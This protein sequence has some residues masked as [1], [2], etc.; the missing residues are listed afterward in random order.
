MFIELAPPTYNINDEYHR[1]RNNWRSYGFSRKRYN[2]CSWTLDWANTNRLVEERPMKLIH[3]TTFLILLL[4]SVCFAY[5]YGHDEGY[6]LVES[7]LKE[8]AEEVYNRCPNVTAYAIMLE[9]ENA[10]LNNCLLYTSPSPRD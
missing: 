6:L 4:I 1:A 9:N 2:D 8:C 5:Q 3:Y 10:R 7:D